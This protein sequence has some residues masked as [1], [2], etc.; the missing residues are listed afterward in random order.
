LKIVALVK[1]RLLKPSEI[2]RKLRRIGMKKITISFFLILAGITAAFGQMHNSNA[3]QEL[4]R[5]NREITDALERFDFAAAKKMT[6]EEYVEID[7]TG[8]VATREEAFKPYKPAADEKYKADISETKIHI[9]GE[10]A[11][12]NYLIQNH[13]MK[14]AYVEED[15]YQVSDFLV[16]RDG[17]WLLVSEHY[18]KLPKERKSIKIDLKTLERYIGHYQINADRTAV[19]TLENDKLMV[20]YSDSEEKRELMPISEKLFFMKDV[21]GTYKFEIDEKGNITGYTRNTCENEPEFR[22]KIK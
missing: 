5:F 16:K 22:R 7:E 13:Y 11:V 2:L 4:M 15:R 3:E 18:S 20:K 6:T 17:R 10:T 1:R 8:K 12:M 21:A 14:G 9:F 19:V